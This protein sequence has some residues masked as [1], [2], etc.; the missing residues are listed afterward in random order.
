MAYIQK[1]DFVQIYK[2]MERLA[3]VSHNE[4]PKSYSNY[5]Y[6]A[7]Y[8]REVEVIKPD[9]LS[10]KE[11]DWRIFGIDEAT[12]EAINQIHSE[13]R[14]LLVNHFTV[15]TVGIINKKYNVNKTFE[16]EEEDKLLEIKENLQTF[17]N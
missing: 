14:T 11:N 13:I 15:E 10:E 4:A 6:L 2:E 17:L 7:K 1:T 8:E 12:G 5:P 16:I 3:K 9:S